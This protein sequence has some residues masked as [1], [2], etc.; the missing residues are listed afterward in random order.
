M[1][2]CRCSG[3]TSM[4]AP[5]WTQEL[6]LWDPALWLL[7]QDQAEGGVQSHRSGSS[8]APV[9]PTAD[10]SLGLPSMGQCEHGTH[11]Q[12]PE[13]GRGN[14]PRRN[15][16]TERV[17]GKPEGRPTFH[18]FPHSL[19][20]TNVVMGSSALRVCTYGKVG[21]KTLLFTILQKI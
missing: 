14:H 11:A 21:W 7:R 5:G 18:R 4:G 1:H 13:K 15:H 12:P 17:S 6:H 10:A 16:P 3:R 9:W 2:T 19:Q 8:R 20:T